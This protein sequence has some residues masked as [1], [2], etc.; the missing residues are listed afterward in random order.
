MNTACRPG[1]TRP[2]FYDAND[3]KPAGKREGDAEARGAGADDEA[4]WCCRPRLHHASGGGE[5]GGR[6]GGHKAGDVVETLRNHLGGEG[7]E[8]VAPTSSSRVSPVWSQEPT[9]GG[10]KDSR[11]HEFRQV[12][13]DT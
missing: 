13:E 5:R 11:P 3:K 8:D 6:D 7:F 12:M 4:Q 10:L 1:A 2:E 9:R